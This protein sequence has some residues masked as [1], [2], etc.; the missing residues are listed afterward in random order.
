LLLRNYLQRGKFGP[1]VIIGSSF[2]Q[3]R[4][5]SIQARLSKL[6]LETNNL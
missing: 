1:P 2:T 4:E 6:P 3:S 5:I